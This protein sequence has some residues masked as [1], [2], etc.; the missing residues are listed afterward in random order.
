M[1]TS[2]LP[3]ARAG[4]SVAG[5]CRTCHPAISRNDGRSRL[6][7]RMPSRSRSRPPEGLPPF[8][9]LVERYGPA[10]LRFCRLRTGPDRAEDCLQ[11]TLLAALRAY[12]EVRDAGAV[13]AWLFAIATRKT[14][15]SH[16][17]PLEQLL[18]LA[19]VAVTTASAAG[20][21]KIHGLD[22][23]VADRL[24]EE[25]TNRTDTAIGDAT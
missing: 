16:R 13:R 24:V 18:G 12:G 4:G 3:Y 15:D 14:V 1:G 7:H 9:R 2:T 17:G 5:R 25:F 20:P 8:E 11:E 21:L 23:D 6:P 19:N 22:R 10:L